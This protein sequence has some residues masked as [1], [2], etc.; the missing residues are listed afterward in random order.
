[1]VTRLQ[2][3]ND[4]SAFT[5]KSPFKYATAVGIQASAV[6]LVVSTLQNAL[7]N[8]SYGAMGVVTRTGGTIGLF[9]AMGATFAFTETAVAN[10]RQTN[11]AWNGAAGACSAG[12]LA[13]VRSRSLPMAVGGCVILGAAMG[14]YDYSGQLAGE[15]SVTKEERRR[16]FFKTPPKPIV[17]VG[18]D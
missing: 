2:E 7:G 14:T 12:F 3:S 5:Y 18:T 17:D 11:D 8:H 4:T 16:N 13:G 1:M 10:Q 15:T 6:G 9:A